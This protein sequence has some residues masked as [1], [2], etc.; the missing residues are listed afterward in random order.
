MMTTASAKSRCP[1]RRCRSRRLTKRPRP[2]LLTI[3]LAFRALHAAS[4]ADPIEDFASNVENEWF[5]AWPPASVSYS[6]PSEL[7]QVG[8]DLGELDTA[9]FQATYIES[10][11]QSERFRWL[12]GGQWQRVQASVPSG[13]PLPDTLQSA[14]AVIGFDWFFHDRWRARLEVFPGVYS[15]F[16]DI[17]GDDFN[18]PFYF[19]VSYALG[20]NLLVGGQL[21]VNVRREAPVLGAVG[22]RWKFAE[23]WLLSLWFP[24][25]RIEYF[26]AEGVTLFAAANIVAGAFV[27]ADDLGRDHSRPDL[28]GQAVDFRQVQIGGGLRYTIREK[29]AIELSGGWTLDQRYDYYD[30]GLEFESSGA[31]YAQIGFGLMF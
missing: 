14:A 31:P 9:I 6:F 22:V 30:R 8:A 27:V 18:A 4:G 21:N 28:D 7:R 17:S 16:Q 15:D 25:P 23:D 19:E 29:L 1:G 3:A 2:F 12:L 11:K 26:P 10:V 24:R 13:V 5:R 20:P